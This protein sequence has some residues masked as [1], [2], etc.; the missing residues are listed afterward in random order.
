MYA[1]AASAY[2][3]VSIESASPARVLDELFR[4]LRLDFRVA[5]ESLAAGDIAPR[6]NALS[7]ALKLVGALEAS[8]DR[9]VAPELC[10]GL[11]KLYAF[12]REQ[13]VAANSQALAAPLDIADEIVAEIHEAFL[14]AQP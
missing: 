13:I 10:E 12:V 8:L 5:K 9:D 7:H 14:Q 11:T 4:R 1:R 3:K 2:K 6:C